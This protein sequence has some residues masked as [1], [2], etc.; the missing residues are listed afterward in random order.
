LQPRSWWGTDKFL[1]TCN[2][3]FDKA[4]GSPAVGRIGWC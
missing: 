1:F 4:L 3:E 2:G